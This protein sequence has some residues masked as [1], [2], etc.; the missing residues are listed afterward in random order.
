MHEWWT[1]EYLGDSTYRKVHNERVHALY[2]YKRS[3]EKYV[4]KKNK[5]LDP[6]KARYWIKTKPMKARQ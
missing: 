6:D 1:E 2:Y 5:R 4:A 3:A